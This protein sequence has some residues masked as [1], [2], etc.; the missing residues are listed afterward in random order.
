MTEIGVENNKAMF[1][2]L[3]VN[4]NSQQGSPGIYWWRSHYNKNVYSRRLE[5]NSASG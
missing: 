3:M 4:P 1:S 5:N 2:E